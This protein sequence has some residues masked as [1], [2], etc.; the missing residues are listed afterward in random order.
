[1]GDDYLKRLSSVLHNS[2][3]LGLDCEEAT[4]RLGVDRGETTQIYFQNIL[5]PLS[6]HLIPSPSFHP[7]PPSPRRVGR[8]SLSSVAG[9]MYP[10]ADLTAFC[11]RTTGDVPPK[12]VVSHM[13]TSVSHFSYPSLSSRARPQQWSAQRCISMYDYLLSLRRRRSL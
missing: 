10:I 3:H 6:I 9:A 7:S 8:P 1:M 12:L 11:R 2:A 5:F 13:N 4:L